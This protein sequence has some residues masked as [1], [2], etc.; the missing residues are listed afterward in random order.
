MPACWQIRSFGISIPANDRR[1]PS[2]H[3]NATHRHRST[4]R[5]RENGSLNLPHPLQMFRNIPPDGTDN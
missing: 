2:A 1:S 3:L 4:I 5:R